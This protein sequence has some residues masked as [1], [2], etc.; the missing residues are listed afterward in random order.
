[1]STKQ[2][3]ILVG[4]CH[5]QG[6][7]DMLKFTNF[8]DKYTV[9]WYANWQ[10][11]QNNQAIP[12]NDLT[13]AD[14]V[15]YQPLSD[16]H[17]CYSTNKKNPNNMFKVCSEDTQLISIPRIHMNCIWPIFKKAANKQEYYG[18]DFLKYYK[19]QG[20]T[21][22][23]QIIK[24][25][26]EGSLDFQFE[27]R[28]N[29]NK[30]LFIEKEYETDIKLFNFIE[31]NMIDKYLFLSQD[32]PTSIVYYECVKQLCKYLDIEFNETFNID[33][34]DDNYMGVP[35]SVYSRSDNRIP[36]SKYSYNH[37]KFNWIQ[38]IDDSFYRNEL[39]NYLLL[40]NM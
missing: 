5:C 15:I 38:N 3:V 6:I 33:T 37:Y 31:Y 13:T 35:D 25:Y 24:L 27:T 40:N 32:H 9:K 39:Y 14:I 34:L 17:G 28:F 21:K 22:V 23:D 10:L 4:L 19:S 8:Y 20:L 2:K 16:I 36:L 7:M 11:I 1:M 30:K 26:D 29:N 18:G 12:Y